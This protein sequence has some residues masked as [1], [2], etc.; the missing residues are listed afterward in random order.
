MLTSTVDHKAASRGASNVSDMDISFIDWEDFATDANVASKNSLAKALT[1]NPK[2]AA[3]NTAS[4]VKVGA[5]KQAAATQ[6]APVKAATPVAQPTKA[7][8]APTKAATPAA[9]PTKAASPSKPSTPAA[10][11]QKAPVKAATPAAQPAKAASSPTKAAAQPAKKAAS[12]SHKTANVPASHGVDI[13]ESITEPSALNFLFSEPAQAQNR[14]RTASN[15]P[16]Q[17]TSQAHSRNVS[18]APAAAAQTHSRTA[19]N[20]KPAAPIA[21]PAKAM[22]AKVGAN[23]IAGTFANDDLTWLAFYE[24]QSHRMFPDVKAPAAT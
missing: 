17:A 16:S 13:W 2:A 4:P 20:A 23:D 19:S 10:Q 11:A 14:S 18:S 9:Q 6:K 21:Q 3:M 22:T 1:T 8:S 5:A 12:P 7:A 24:P 15:A